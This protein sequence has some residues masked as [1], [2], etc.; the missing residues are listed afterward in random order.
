MVHADRQQLRQV[1][2]N[3]ITNGCDAMPDGGTLT[4]R[5]ERVRND[6]REQSS[7]EADADQNYVR[8]THSIVIDIS[9]TG[10]GIPADVLPHILEP[11]FTTKPQ[12]KGTGLGLAICR[13]IVQ[14]HNGKLEIRSEVGQGTTIRILLPA[15]DNGATSHVG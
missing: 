2:L 15:S 14:E 7:F 8:T 5:V 3:L 4:I 1:M 6:E 13:R 10:T 11:F 9:D 12:G